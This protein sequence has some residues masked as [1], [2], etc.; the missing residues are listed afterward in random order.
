SA[1]SA[2]PIVLAA[3]VGRA[4]A[5]LTGGDRHGVSVGA[6]LRDLSVLGPASVSDEELAAVL[7][8]VPAAEMAYTLVRR[9]SGDLSDWLVKESAAWLRERAATLGIQLPADWTGL[10][11]ISPITLEAGGQVWLV[12]DRTERDVF[13]SFP[14]Q[15]G[16]P[17][18]VVVD[19]GQVDALVSGQRAVASCGG[20]E[21]TLLTLPSPKNADLG[22]L[23]RDLLAPLAC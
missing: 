10:D 4:A 15:V 14:W 16:E 17:A 6:G 21:F 19:V 5:A 7:L 20:L 8:S 2:Q 12:V 13:E 22:E 23:L 11:S 1:A 3:G 18:P 9:G